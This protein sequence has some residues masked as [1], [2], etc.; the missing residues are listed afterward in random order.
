MALADLQ[1]RKESLNI[2][3]NLIIE[4]GAGGGKTSIM[5]QRYLACLLNVD[6]PEQVLFCTFT[7]AATQEIA[8]RVSDALMRAT[9]DERPTSDYEAT[10]YD[11][12]RQVLK[13]DN[14]KEWGLLVNSS[15]MNIITLDGLSAKIAKQMPVLS[16][17]GGDISVTDDPFPL[18]NSAAMSVLEAIEE[19]GEISKDVESLMLHMNGNQQ[20]AVELISQMLVKRDQWLRHV[21]NAGDVL[22][23]TEKEDTLLDVVNNIE[24]SA[25]SSISTIKSEL[26]DLLEF[27]S[28]N[29]SSDHALSKGSDESGY[30]ERVA[31]LMLTGKGELRKSVTKAQG[32]PSGKENAAMKEQWK[33]IASY[34]PSSAISALVSVRRLPSIHY[35]E[36]QWSLL[37][38][39]FRILLR[40]AAELSVLFARE[41]KVDFSEVSAR[42]I[43]SLMPDNDDQ[44]V[45]Q[46]LFSVLRHIIIDEVQDI[47]R[48]QYR[49]IELL[50][51]EWDE[52]MNNSLCLVG[53]PK[54]SIYRFREAD[55]GLFLRA[56]EQGIAGI[57]LE[58]INLTTNFRSSEVIVDFNNKVY[59]H[60]FPNKT[61]I[62]LGAMPYANSIAGK[63]S[64]PLDG[65]KTWALNDE[66]K[67]HEAKLAV[68]AVKESFSID[69]NASVAILVRS[70]SHLSH[71]AEELV[72][73]GIEYQAVEIQNIAQ[74]G[75]VQDALALSKAIMHP[76]D[77]IGWLSVLRAPS[78]ALDLSDLTL[79]CENI[80]DQSIAER[81]FDDSRYSNMSKHGQAIVSK[82]REV[83]MRVDQ[84]R[85][86]FCAYTLIKSAWFQLSMASGYSLSDIEDVQKFFSVLSEFEGKSMLNIA[87]V[88]RKMESLYANPSS[89]PKANQVQLMT[90]HKSKGLE[91]DV[92][93]LPNLGSR[94]YGED[95]S[96][97]MWHEFTNKDT[98]HPEMLLAPIK[99][100]GDD[101]IYD[102]L[103][104][105]EKEKSANELVRVLYVATTRARYRLY[106]IGHTKK[107]KPTASSLLASLWPKLSP[108]EVDLDALEADEDA[109]DENSPEDV[110]MP[111]TQ[112]QRS[113][114]S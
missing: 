61:D 70:R 4:A 50:V 56:K 16:G 8:V 65:I 91:F 27:A 107:G 5:V 48:T 66:S 47:N 31:E 29:V 77:N 64:H 11:L 52:T 60:L 51:S 59:Q 105:I 92:V 32:F 71:I 78:Q 53:D 19:G 76:M 49:Q 84:L 12:A 88:E 94:G 80:D 72:K 111:D 67:E 55:V 1:A 9:S 73:E 68:S 103:M 46:R 101:D 83:L 109:L 34:L 26:D 6:F 57:S 86:Q 37:S 96:L 7:R 85:T 40:A 100:A 99:G 87:D 43:A 36:D 108:E 25:L 35:S 30:L 17:M 45:A 54:Q 110:R 23:K 13:R 69:E 113:I 90:I 98:G 95:G 22:N 44:A 63:T 102:F 81:L 3:K 114:I 39:L 75:I 62:A 89:S 106:M 41:G 2:T 42:A 58:S 97:V 21:A 24:Q 79:L 82:M 93:I 28:A 33:T 20:R 10:T 18:Y 112:L 104:S 15:R 38:S 14:A 74:K